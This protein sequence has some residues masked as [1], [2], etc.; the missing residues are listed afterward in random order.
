[1]QN[2]MLYS[3][4]YMKYEMSRKGNYIKTENRSVVAWGWGWEQRTTANKHKGTFEE[5]E[6]CLTEL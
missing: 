6:N 1:M 5:D 3:S 4:S 2:I